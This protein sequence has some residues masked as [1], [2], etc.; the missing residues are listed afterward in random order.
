MEEKRK[1]E[2]KEGRKE[3]KEFMNQT[4]VRMNRWKTDSMQSL[5]TIELNSSFV[6]ETGDTKNNY[7]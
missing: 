4:N 7:L 5:R 3:E 1:E 6:F 2:M